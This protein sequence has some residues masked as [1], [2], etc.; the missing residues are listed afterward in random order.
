MHKTD[1]TVYCKHHTKH[2]LY[3]MPITACSPV[4]IRRP[5][6][7][8]PIRNYEELSQ[9]CD[10]INL[11]HAILTILATNAQSRKPLHFTVTAAYDTAMCVVLVYHVK[12]C[13]VAVYYLA[14]CVVAKHNLA[15]LSGYSYVLSGEIRSGSVLSVEV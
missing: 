3:L 11:K 8:S 13:K 4:E 10:V 2:L 12:N 7:P 14:K 6:P 1:I 5:E 15:V 9:L